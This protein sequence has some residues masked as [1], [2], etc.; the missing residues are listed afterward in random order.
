MIGAHHASPQKPNGQ[1]RA[2]NM[3][4]EHHPPTAV[5]VYASERATA[6]AVLLSLMRRAW[7]APEI[8]CVKGYAWVRTVPDV[9]DGQALEL[10]Q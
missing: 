3:V 7:T 8:A 1:Q 10:R 2:A 5:Q 9:G 6:R 4:L